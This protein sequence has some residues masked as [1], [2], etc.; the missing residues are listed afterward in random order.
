MSVKV[1][2]WEGATKLEAEQ[3]DQR[4]WGDP[5]RSELVGD[6]IGGKRGPGHIRHP[7]P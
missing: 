3:E 6:E 7:S 5:P 2:R 4:G 1:L